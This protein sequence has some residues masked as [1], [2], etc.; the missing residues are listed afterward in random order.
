MGG[1]SEK[2]RYGIDVFIEAGIVS[3]LTDKEELQPIIHHAVW[4]DSIPGTERLIGGYD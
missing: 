3:G 4:E 1:T 2:E